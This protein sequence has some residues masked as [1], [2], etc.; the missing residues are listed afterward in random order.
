MAG[1]TMA[2]ARSRVLLPLCINAF[3]STQLAVVHHHINDSFEWRYW[4]GRT[5]ELR[6]TRGIRSQRTE[7]ASRKLLLNPLHRRHID[8][9]SPNRD[10]KDVFDTRVMSARAGLCMGLR[11]S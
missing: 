4:I 11:A 7:V 2:A 10:E 6:F 1:V 5:P 9:L 8:R 3:I